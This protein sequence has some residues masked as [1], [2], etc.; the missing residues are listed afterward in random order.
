MATVIC[1]NCGSR[2]ALPDHGYNAQGHVI[3]KDDAG[4]YELQME[5]EGH[6]HHSDDYISSSLIESSSIESSS[7]ESMESTTKNKVG[8]MT[9]TELSLL[10]SL[11][12]RLKDDPAAKQL[13]RDMALRLLHSDIKTYREAAEMFRAMEKTANC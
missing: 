3:G 7:I 6:Y 2:V 8:I 4:D 13:V 11:L 12:N 1:P 9:D 10:S 5:S